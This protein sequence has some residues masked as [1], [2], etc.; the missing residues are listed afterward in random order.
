MCDETQASVSSL[1]TYGKSVLR[2]CVLIAVAFGSMGCASND[3]WVYVDNAGKKPMVVTVDGKEE[4]NI[5][6]GEFETLKFE[7]GVRRFHIQCGD[8]VL[9]ND[10]KDLKQSDTLGMG[11]RYFFNPDKRNRYATYSVKYGS[12]PLDGMFDKLATAA[13]REGQLRYAH[14]KL[15]KEVTLLPSG[16][17]FEVPN[18][19]YVLTNPPEFVTT[20]GMTER[21]TV[22][23]RIAP[24]DYAFLEAASKKTNPSERDV[25]ALSD[26]VERVLDSEPDGAPAEQP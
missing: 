8:K 13:D 16:G 24:K 7:P 18:G 10:T 20:R 2:V 11:R 1:S 23:T 12:S 17:W 21:R 19:A 26:V 22:L 5:A 9:F 6:P 4:A 25:E 14:Q 15:L 3:V